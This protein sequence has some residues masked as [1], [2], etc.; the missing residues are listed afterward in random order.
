MTV[1]SNDIA[2]MA[3]KKLN[4]EDAMLEAEQM[5]DLF[6]DAIRWFG[7]HPELFPKGVFVTFANIYEFT[8]GTGDVTSCP[9]AAFAGF[10]S[11]WSDGADAFV[12]I[13]EQFMKLAVEE[14]RDM[15]FL[16]EHFC[17]HGFKKD[18]PKIQCYEA[19][20]QLWFDPFTC[21]HPNN[22]GHIEISKMFMSVVEE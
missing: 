17:G 19:G 13:M 6:R 20:A 12:H 18:D 1:G 3:Q 5:L 11:A 9:V 16:Q 14:N 15:I 2:S 22:E 8:D 7:D 4:A 10:D 21:T